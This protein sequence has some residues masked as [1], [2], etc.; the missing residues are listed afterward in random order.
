LRDRQHA[1]PGAPD[2]PH[3]GMRMHR[4]GAAM[5]G[6]HMFDMADANKDGRV[7]LQEATDTAVH[8][9]DMA[10]ANRDGRIT[11]DE[12]RTMHRQ[13]IEKRR[14]PKAG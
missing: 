7:T 3:P 2:M 10:D 6:G 12:R 5:M 9:F 1:A 11:P 13:M 14:A 4:M 8:H